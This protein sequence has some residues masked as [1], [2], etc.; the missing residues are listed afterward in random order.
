MLPTVIA[1]VLVFLVGQLA[2]KCIIE[3]V[4][5]LKTTIARVGNLMLLYQAKLLNASCED[6]IAGDLKKLSAD[7]ISDSYRILGFPVA[8][9]FFGLP[10]REALLN[11]AKE[12]N[13]LHYVML[14]VARQADLAGRHE[15]TSVASTRS[16]TAMAKVGTL[17]G[18]KTDYSTF[19]K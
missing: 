15:S 13:T 11:A 7:L 18:V 6:A 12:L 3:P 5:E 8:R 14:P 10:S 17:L 2:L 4:Q 16:F 19:Q 1:G 9:L